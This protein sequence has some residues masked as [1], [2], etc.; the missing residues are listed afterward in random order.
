[1]ERGDTRGASDVRG[2]GVTRYASGARG[3]RRVGGPAADRLGDDE[4]EARRVEPVLGH[5]S[6][7]I[8]ECHPSLL[9]VVGEG[10]R[11]GGQ[12]AGLVLADDERPGDQAG[13]QP[14][15]RH[16]LG[17]LGTLG[18]FGA[19]RPT[20]HEQPPHHLQAGRGDEPHGRRPA[21]VGPQVDRWGQLPEQ[22]GAHPTA[23]VVRVD[24]EFGSRVLGVRVGDLG[25]PHEEVTGI[26]EQVLGCAAGQRE[27][28]L[29]GQGTG[30]VDGLG[31]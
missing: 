11:I 23:S 21:A 17:P 7:Q 18:T 24:N 19:E 8:G 25:V 5:P 4:E 1:V 30:A 9:G 13:G 2:G 6:L 20:Q 29:F 22:C 31:R 26:P 10:G 3:G 27:A 12:P 14:R 15:R 28:E 16:G